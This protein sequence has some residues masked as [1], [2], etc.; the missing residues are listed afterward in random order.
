MSDQQ[1]SGKGFLKDKLG[2]YQVNPPESVW[3]SIRLTIG[4]Q[5][6]KEYHSHYTICCCY[7]GPGDYPGYQFLWT[8]TC[9]QRGNR[10]NTRECRSGPNPEIEEIEAL[11]ELAEET[12][13]AKRREPLEVKVGRALE[14]IQLA[15][16]QT[17]ILLSPVADQATDKVSEEFSEVQKDFSDLG[18]NPIVEDVE[19]RENLEL[20]VNP[21]QRRFRCHR[22]FRCCRKPDGC[23]KPGCYRGTGI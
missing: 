8:R 2:D 9:G 3:D 18:D 20:A 17:E 12:E 23:R 7:N 13:T 21:M 19:T 10:H 11:Q 16:N 15:E 22:R 4:W 14:D 5:Q 1:N 6:Q